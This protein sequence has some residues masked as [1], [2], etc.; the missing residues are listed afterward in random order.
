MLTEVC[1]SEMTYHLGFAIKYV[2]RNIYKMDNQQGP[3]V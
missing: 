3:T 2:S 1:S